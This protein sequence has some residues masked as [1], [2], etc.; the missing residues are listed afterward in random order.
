MGLSQFGVSRIVFRDEIIDDR[1]RRFTGPLKS[2]ILFDQGILT[3]G[4]KDGI[5]FPGEDWRNFLLHLS[6]FNRVDPEINQYRFCR[7][8]SSSGRGC[9]KCVELCPSGAQGN[10]IPLQSGGYSK[11]VLKR[12][13][14]FYDDQL[15]FDFNLCTDDRVQMKTLYSEWSCARCVFVCAGKGLKRKS[16]VKKFSQIKHKLTKD[17]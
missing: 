12:S 11:K 6:D 16:A 15:Q 17:I 3:T 7:Y 10:S 5:F 13:R 9:R 4:K 2:I 1:V 8:P 14:W